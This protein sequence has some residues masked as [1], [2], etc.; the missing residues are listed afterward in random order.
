MGLST[1]KQATGRVQA[2]QIPPQS[3]P[4]SVPFFIPSVQVGVTVTVS[5]LQLLIS[6]TENNNTIVALHKIVL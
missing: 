6:I 2:L 4:V 3:I 5:F 1:V